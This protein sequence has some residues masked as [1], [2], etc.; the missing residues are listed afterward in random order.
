METYVIKWKFR[1]FRPQIACLLTEEIWI[2]YWT[3]LLWMKICKRFFFVCFSVLQ[4][5]LLKWNHTGVSG[6]WRLPVI[7]KCVVSLVVKTNLKWQHSTFPRGHRSISQ[8]HHTLFSVVCHLRW[9]GLMAWILGT[10]QSR[11]WNALAEINVKACPS[12]TC[13]LPV[14]ECSQFLPLV[15]AKTTPAV[16][17]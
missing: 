4:V 10:L 17:L 6:K 12:S 5:S 9:R 15:N 13:T 7:K 8:N 1:L 16:F 14:L 11:L 3:F 2:F